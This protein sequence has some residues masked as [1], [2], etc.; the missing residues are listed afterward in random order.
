MGYL[1]AIKREEPCFQHIVVWIP[2]HS[3]INTEP[4]LHVWYLSYVKCIVLVFATAFYLYLLGWE[5]A[6]VW[7]VSGGG[8]V[9]LQ[10][11]AR[12]L[13]WSLLMSWTRL[14]QEFDAPEQVSEIS[15]TTKHHIYFLKEQN[16]INGSMCNTVTILMVSLWSTCFDSHSRSRPLVFSAPPRTGSAP[17]H[18]R[19]CSSSELKP[20]H[21][22]VHSLW[23]FNVSTKHVH[24]RATS[25]PESR[26]VALTCLR[27]KRNDVP[28]LQWS[29]LASRRLSCIMKNELWQKEIEIKSIITR[30]LAF[31]SCFII[32]HSW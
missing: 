8:R 29:G 17:Y 28:R 11:S 20:L 6:Q 18:F 26:H 3:G 1:Y 12:R 2:L 10:P 15:I 14:C 19:R 9:S 4:T 24:E 32:V 21:V 25:C 5:E 30:I 22:L 13:C 27:R 7:I 16:I 23:M 31:F